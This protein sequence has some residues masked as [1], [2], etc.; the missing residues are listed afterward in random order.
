MY[1]FIEGTKM[2]YTMYLIVIVN[3]EVIDGYVSFASETMF[4]TSN[5]FA[6]MCLSLIVNS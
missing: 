3:P 6:R 2:Y 1:W 5:V 4:S